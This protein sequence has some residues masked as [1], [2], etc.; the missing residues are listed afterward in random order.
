M[1]TKIHCTRSGLVYFSVCYG[2]IS[3]WLAVHAS[4]HCTCTL[5]VLYP[6]VK[7]CVVGMLSFPLDANCADDES[8]SIIPIPPYVSRLLYPVN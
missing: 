8:T 5:L 2:E 6:A 1:D 3:R 4:L 7:A